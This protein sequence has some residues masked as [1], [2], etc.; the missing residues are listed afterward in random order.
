MKGAA[1]E[2]M[3]ATTVHVERMCECPFAIAQEYAEQYLRQAEAGGPQAR[4]RAPLPFLGQKV[5]MSFGLWGDIAE[6]GHQHE[7]IHLR[8]S[9]GS[10]WLP[11]F[12]GSIRFRIDGRNTLILVDGTFTPPLGWFGVRFDQLVGRRIAE[13]GLY[14]LA[15]RIGDQLERKERAWHAAHWPTRN[16]LGA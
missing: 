6:G 10:K 1:A 3:P 16:E 14:D 15:G 11:D 2:I 9:S 5:K 12:R 8:W 4:I 13:Y 7:E